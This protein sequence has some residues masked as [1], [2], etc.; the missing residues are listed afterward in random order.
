MSAEPII[1]RLAAGVA[2]F[3][4]AD[5][6]RCAGDGDPFV[7]HAFLSALEESRSAAAA[8]G[9][10][11]LPVAI[12]GP[13]GR[14]DAVLPAYVKSHSQGEYVFDHGWA[15]AWE[16]AGGS[17]YPKLQ[18]AVPFTPVPGRRLLAREPVLAPALI[19]AAERVVAAH[20]LSS[21]HA[22]SGADRNSCSPRPR[23]LRCST[24]SLRRTSPS[25]TRTARASA[26]GATG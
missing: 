11:P 16:R 8:T 21:A 17:Y 26:S 5:W 6:D 7:S 24:I 1:A 3:A 14:P 22:C 25:S 13:D 4:A 10:Q 19:A 15:D 9:W 23:R 12:D 20:A 2:S 18:I